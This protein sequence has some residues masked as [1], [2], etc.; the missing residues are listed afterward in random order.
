LWYDGKYQ[1]PTLHNEDGDSVHFVVC[2]KQVPETSEV[3]IDPVRGTLQ[4]EGVDSKMNPFDLHALEAAVQ[5]KEQLGGTVT[6]VSMGPP[7]AAA[8]IK[9]AYALGADRGVL[10]SDR[11]FAGADTLA[12]GYTLSQAIAKLE[13]SVI[14]CGMQTIDGDTAQVGPAIAE[15]LA[16]PHVAYVKRI[17]SLDAEQLVVEMDMTDAVETSQGIIVNNYHAKSSVPNH[18]RPKAKRDFP[19]ADR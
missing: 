14:F 16:I 13:P 7:Q 9:E 3:E 5:L 8:V 6:V 17:T 10:L 18:N 1:L 4:R 12:T 2:I 11:K 15:M 19:H